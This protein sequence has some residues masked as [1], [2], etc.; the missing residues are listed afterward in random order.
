MSGSSRITVPQRDAL[1]V[2]VLLPLIAAAGAAIAWATV[3]YGII[4]VAPL[5][6]MVVTL[7]VLAMVGLRVA[8]LLLILALA[9]PFRSQFLF[10]GVDLHT[11]HLLIPLVALL[12]A[13]QLAYGQLRLP[14]GLLP[15]LL[16][17]LLGGVIAALAGTDPGGSLTRLIF[18]LA[19]PMLVAIVAATVIKPERDI[20]PLTN[21]LA[22]ALCGLGLLSLA[23]LAGAAPG[24]LGPIFGEDR[25]NGLFYHPNILGAYLAANIVLFA[26]I[27]A[28]RG[29]SGVYLLVPIALGLAGLVATLARGPFLGLIAGLLLVTVLLATRR[30]ASLLAIVVI[31]P[32]VAAVA[33]PEAPT[34]QRSALS[35][36]FN[37]AFEP[38]AEA[39][40]KAIWTDAERQI[41]AYPL[42]G[43]GALTFADEFSRSASS[44]NVDDNVTHAHNLF[45]EGYLSL[46]PLG[47][48]G[49]VWLLAGAVQRLWRSSRDSGGDGKIVAGWSI[50]AIGALLSIVVSSMVDFP[51]WQLE[52]T[53]FVFLLVGAA[54]AQGAPE[55]APDAQ[56]AGDED[57]EDRSA[58]AAMV[59]S[60]NRSVA[61]A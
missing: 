53:A 26:G 57:A 12:A 11:T 39:G 15:P 19:L 43:I 54:Y 5:F 17:M 28:Y 23:Q 20:G 60:R 37:E 30:P 27:A 31:V 21:V 50:G 7:G 1:M 46:G 59:R 61:S 51:F 6:V 40:R 44:T 49:L 52:V 34:E 33:L 25:V 22:L 8:F 14:R 47:M 42:T 45:L 10:E 29:A 18:G 41:A 9:F 38:D 55:S 3:T 24:P 56:A 4:T 13:V 48:I 36:R 35:D 16:V 32:I 2:L 58:K